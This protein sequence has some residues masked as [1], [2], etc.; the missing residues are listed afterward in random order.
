MYCTNVVSTANSQNKINP[1]FEP[2]WMHPENSRPYLVR[3]IP[4]DSFSNYLQDNPE[5]L[6]LQ[7]FFWK[8][9]NPY[10]K[11]AIAGLNFTDPKNQFD[12]KPENIL[13]N[14]LM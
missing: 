3:K 14:P 6:L 11:N 9:L 10:L 2:V 5:K 12:I 13:V 8:F 7:N 1:I 4:G